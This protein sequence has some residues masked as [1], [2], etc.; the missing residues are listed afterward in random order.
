MLAVVCAFFLFVAFAFLLIV[1]RTFALLVLFAFIC[2]MFAF[3]AAFMLALVCVVVFMIGWCVYTCFRFECCVSF[4]PT[5]N[6]E[7]QMG[8]F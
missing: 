8:V 7:A 5:C 4:E 1:V 3:N 2:L 6:R